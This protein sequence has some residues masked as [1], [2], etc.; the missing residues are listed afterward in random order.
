MFGARFYHETTRR[1][2]A[3]FGTL[4][5]DLVITRSDNNG[6]AVQSM[7]VPIHYAPVQKILARLQQDPD[8]SAPAMTLPRMSFEILSMSYDGERKVNSTLRQTKPTTTNSNEFDSVFTPVPYNIEFQLNIMAKYNEDGT[9]I[10]E[11][12]LPY[13]K[14][15]F[16]ASVKLL[17]DLDMYMD[18]PIILNSISFEDTYESD[19]QTRRSLIWTL[20]FTMKAYYFGPASKKKVIKFVDVNVYN[21]LT[22]SQL[23]QHITV[24]PGLTTN[25]EPT[26]DPTTSIDYN[27]IFEDDN[28]AYI[29]QIEDYNG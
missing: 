25:N 16:T 6:T 3:T 8:F 15:D 2:V 11:Q 14:P 21:T 18:V 23:I 10:I 26:T 13:F 22:A 7:K 27:N 29:V 5:N 24:Q 19:F 20:T 17:D 28:W 9:K 4:F 1:Y 12:I